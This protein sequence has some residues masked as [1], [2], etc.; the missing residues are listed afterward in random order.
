M[1][2]CVACQPGS[3]FH[4]HNFTWAIVF[5]SK[6]DQM[7]ILTITSCASHWWRRTVDCWRNISD[8]CFSLRVRLR[9]TSHL[10]T[11]EPFKTVFI[12]S[13]VEQSHLLSIKPST[14]QH[15]WQ[16]KHLPWLFLLLNFKCLELRNQKLSNCWTD[17]NWEG[18]GG[19]FRKERRQWKV[20]PP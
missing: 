9:T 13:A 8:L 1:C 17:T 10:G 18:K 15:G 14:E 7:G 6:T 2:V 11:S 19:T 16:T 3:I 12:H 20:R 4:T 5:F